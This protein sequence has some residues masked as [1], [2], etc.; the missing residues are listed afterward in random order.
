MCRKS[1]WR[2]G[3]RNE[4]AGSPP[5][6]FLSKRGFLTGTGRLPKPPLAERNPFLV[7]IELGS[8]TVSDRAMLSVHFARLCKPRC[9]CPYLF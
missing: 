5:E 4:L 6:K 3:Y 7:L 8:Y 9:I 1:A 2:P